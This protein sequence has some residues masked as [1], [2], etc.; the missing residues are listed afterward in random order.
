MEYLQPNE[1]ILTGKWL[2]NGGGLHS[3]ETCLRIDWLV[4]DVLKKIAVSKQ[5]G[6]WEI[7]FQDPKDGRYWEKVYPESNMHGGGP[8][9]LKML[10]L[11]EAKIKYDF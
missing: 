11:E 3:D 2:T 7:L 8:P 4:T 1:T 9:A 5:W 10:S 6:A